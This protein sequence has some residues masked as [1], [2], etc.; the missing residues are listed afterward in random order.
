MFVRTNSLR[1]GPDGMLWVVDTGTA[2][3]GEKIVRGGVKLV[4][5]NL[6]TNKVASVYPLDEFTHPESFVDDVRFHGRYAF[7]TDAGSP[8][9]IVLNLTTGKARRVLENDRSTTANRIVVA[10]GNALHTVDGNVVR[11]HADQLEVSPDGRYL[12]YQALTWPMY[13][14]ETHYL[15]DPHV[16]KE[17]LAEKV[18]FFSN[19]PNTGGT[20]IE[21]SGT[22]YLSDVE[23]RRILAINPSGDQKVLLEDNRLDWPD[24]MWIDGDGYLWMPV[25]QLDKIAPFQGG[26]S[27][28]VYPIRIYKMRVTRN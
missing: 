17:V 16:S 5:I 1:I 10:S 15:E 9:L 24:A 25:A 4:S 12:Y 7:L 28:V 26:K 11:I 23:R 21:S 8:A 3:F 22:I 14:I 13:R 20:A 27:Q 6:P 18:S 19:T 2:K